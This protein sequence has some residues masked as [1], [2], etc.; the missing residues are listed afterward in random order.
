[1][2][3]YIKIEIS[4]FSKAMAIRNPLLT[5]FGAQQLLQADENKVYSGRVSVAGMSV[6]TRSITSRQSTMSFM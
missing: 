4:D 2:I 3:V 6:S 1:M 5:K